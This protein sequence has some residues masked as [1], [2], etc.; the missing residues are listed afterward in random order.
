MDDF[1]LHFA[2][3]IWNLGPADELATLASARRVVTDN[4]TSMG[5]E[6]LELDISISFNLI[7]RFSRV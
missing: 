3:A 7:Q 1:R 4:A 2:Q 5:Q 6:K